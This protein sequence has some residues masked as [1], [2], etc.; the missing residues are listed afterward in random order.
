MPGRCSRGQRVRGRLARPGPAGHILYTTGLVINI[1]R[2]FTNICK[3]QG[4]HVTLWCLDAPSR[5]AQ[6]A[7]VFAPSRPQR[8]L[9]ACLHPRNPARHPP[10]TVPAAGACPPPPCQKRLRIQPRRACH[11]QACR[12]SAPSSA[13]SPAEGSA[14]G[15]ASTPRPRTA[16]CLH[17]ASAAGCQ[18][19]HSLRPRLRRRAPPAARRPPARCAPSGWRRALRS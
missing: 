4:R 19:Q 17:A 9:P 2:M 7:Q 15:P 6:A 13:L 18:V 5:P 1:T 14:R 16:R 8:A 3:P 10:A 12:S 11:R